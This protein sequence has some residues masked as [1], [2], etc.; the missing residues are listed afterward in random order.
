M[1]VQWLRPRTSNAGGAGS[2]PGWETKDPAYPEVQPKQTNP[3][4]KKKQRAEKNGALERCST[5]QKWLREFYEQEILMFHFG[6]DT[7][8]VT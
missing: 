4:K 1:A 5:W 7:T 2:S 6:S 8:E 3:K